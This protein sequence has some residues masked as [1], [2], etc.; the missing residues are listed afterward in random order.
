MMT[1]YDAAASAQ[2]ALG[3]R[4]VLRIREISGTDYNREVAS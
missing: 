4:H 3:F 2:T 1:Y